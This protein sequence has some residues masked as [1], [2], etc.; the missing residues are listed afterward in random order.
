[1][2][3]FPDFDPATIPQPGDQHNADVRARQAAFQEAFG[4]FQGAHVA[5]F[6][7]GPAPKGEWVGIIF[8]VDGKRLKVAVPFTLW[9]RFGNEYALAMMTAAELAD[10][11]YSNPGGKA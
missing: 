8:E 5:G 4:D 3:H 6:W 11:A 7:A 1:M 2:T 9:Q 10:L